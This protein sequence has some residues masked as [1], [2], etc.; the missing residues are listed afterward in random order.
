MNALRIAIGAAQRPVGQGPEATGGNPQKKIYL[1][2]SLYAT[3]AELETLEQTLANHISPTIIS[4]TDIANTGATLDTGGEFTPRS[5]KDAR[6][7]ILT[8]IAQRQGQPAFRK[9]LLAEYDHKCAITHCDSEDA[10][11]AA[12]ILP[13]NGHA[14]NIIQNGLL[15]RA[16]IHILFDR[17]LIAINT[18][19]WTITLHERIRHSH[20]AS[21]HGQKLRLPQKKDS[22]P[23]IDALNKHRVES[24]I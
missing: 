5:I 21:L 6:N 10:L 2:T 22:H 9:Q 24:G 12:H 1:Y 15:L 19:D 23:S 4:A 20:Y 7:R 8:A 16:D 11:E 13:Y 3:E 17:G 18:A 14:T